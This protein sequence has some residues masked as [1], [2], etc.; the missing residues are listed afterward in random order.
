M[1]SGN[2]NNDCEILLD[3]LRTLKLHGANNRSKI[4]V[5]GKTPLSCV[6][7]YVKFKNYSNGNP[8]V[9]ST[10]YP[11]YYNSKLKTNYP[12]LEPILKE[13]ADLH[14]PKE[15][16]YNQV[17]INKN[18]KTLKHKDAKNVGLSYIV[19][20]GNYEGGNLVVVDGPDYFESEIN[21]KNKPYGFDGSEK[22]HYTK[23]FKGTRYSIV[24][25][26]NNLLK[27]NL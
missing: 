16:E 19:G 10:K 25:Y 21:I 14:L 11:G 4:N 27:I 1:F 20:L 5:D 26:Q 18:F 2:L 17:V 8:R 6:Y 23:E 22:F 9:E 15:F 7:G 24:F 12:E 3:K 13:W